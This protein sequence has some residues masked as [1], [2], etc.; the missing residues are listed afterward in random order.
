MRMR[1]VD[2]GEE[3]WIQGQRSG[4]RMLSYAYGGFRGRAV[5]LGAEKWIQ[6]V[7]ICVHVW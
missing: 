1:T 5:D 6:D 7:V 2:S 3:R 4:F